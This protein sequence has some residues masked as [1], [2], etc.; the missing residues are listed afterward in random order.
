[1][2]YKPLVSI[3]IPV[4]NGANYLTQAIESVLAQTYGNIEILVINDGSVDDGATEVIARSFGNKTRY[5]K[6]E[7]GGVSTAL[8]YGISQMNGDWFSWLSHDDLYMPDKIKSQIDRLVLLDLDKNN[9]IL[10]CGSDLIDAKGD[11]IFHPRRELCGLFSGKEI[12]QKLFNGRNLN[13]CSLL[14]PKAVLQNTGGFNSEYKYIQ[15]FVYWV[16]TAQNETFFYLYDKPLVKIR[17]H[18]Q[19]QTNFLGEHLFKK[20]VG[21]F[22]EGYTRKLGANFKENLFYLIIVLYYCSR[23]NNKEIRRNVVD[24]L[25]ENNQYTFIIRLKNYYFRIYGEIRRAAIKC[26]RLLF[27]RKHQNNIV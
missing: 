5:F 15:D 25:K 21:N 20:E 9:T 11:K 26:Y 13:G 12:F 14:I 6:K 7:N 4:Y 27:I 10:S 16:T 23:I 24:L 2:T 3:I 1:M 17:I 8:N 22:L 19:Q 18:S